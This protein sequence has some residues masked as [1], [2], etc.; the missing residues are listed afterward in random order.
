[1]TESRSCVATFLLSANTP[2]SVDDAYTTSVN[3]PL[4]VAPRGVLTNDS[5]RAGGAMTATLV[6]GA[7]HGVVTL[8]TNGGFTYTPSTG[9]IGADS[10]TYRAVNINGPS[11]NVATALITVESPPS[12]QSPV[13]LVV[14][15]VVGQLVTV[16]FTPPVLGPVP[17]GYVLRGGVSPGQV[18]ATLPTGDTAP[19]F[20]F[21]APSGS[22]FIRMHT[23]TSAGESEASN[24]V[25]LHVGVP[26]P[27]S[28]PANLTGL[29]NGSLLALAWKNTFG[30]GP[31]SNTFLD[32]TGSLTA[33]LPMGVTENFSFPS[34]PGGTYT[35]RVRAVN[36]GGTSA[37]SDA[38]MLT[39]PGPC[40][41]AP[42]LP[43][44]FLANKIGNT[45]SVLWD[46]PDS[47]PAPTQYVLHVTGSLVGAF[48]ISGRSISSA[49]APGTYR[50][51]RQCGKSLRIECADA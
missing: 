26:V 1:M 49:V 31:P 39:F 22:F 6:S 27:P 29:V 21:V 40:S 42:E 37:P 12:P 11:G 5:S 50:L 32:V 30:G 14:D 4:I 2:V 35:L 23:V 44:N 46:P 48:P 34:V 51:E 45:I 33:S 28:P 8:D 17:T 47:G 41:G 43:G 36:A 19:I 38:V 7:S 15:S 16:R 25:R 24:E 9:F 3:N 10:F 13:G 20:R 18:L